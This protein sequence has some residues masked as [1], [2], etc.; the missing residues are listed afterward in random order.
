MTDYYTFIANSKFNTIAVANSVLDLPKE[1]NIYDFLNYQYSKLSDLDS[2]QTYSNKIKILNN[3]KIV[4]WD[5]NK[6]K[7]LLDHIYKEYY[8]KV[9]STDQFSAFEIAAYVFK[10]LCPTLREHILPFIVKICKKYITTELSRFDNKQ[11][12]SKYIL[13]EKTLKFDIFVKISLFIE[14]ASIKPSLPEYQPNIGESLI[15]YFDK[16][17]DLVQLE[18]QRPLEIPT[19]FELSNALSMMIQKLRF[20]NYDTLVEVISENDLIVR[21]INVGK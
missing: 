14:P 5:K 8:L 2:L 1:D 4:P 7:S 10:A 17:L 13:S 18:N 16:I 9:L 6:T 20:Q 3:L 19:S 15:L 11:N 12:T 21:V